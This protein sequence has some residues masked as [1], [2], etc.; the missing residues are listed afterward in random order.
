MSNEFWLDKGIIQKEKRGEE[1]I[2]IWPNFDEM[3]G[4]W[5]FTQFNHRGRQRAW[6]TN[7]EYGSL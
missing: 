2:W 4:S 7:K 1:A 5:A 3:D 6:A